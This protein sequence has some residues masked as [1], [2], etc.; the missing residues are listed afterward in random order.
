MVAVERDAL[1]LA[2]AVEPALVRELGP[3]DAVRAIL[4]DAGVAEPCDLAALPWRGTPLLTVRRRR[5]A[6]ERLFV[7][8]DAAS[9][10]EPFTGEG[11][12]WAIAGAL[13]AAPLVEAAVAGWEPSLASRWEV[14]YK[15]LLGQRQAFCRQLSLALR[16]PRA[17]SC[18]IALL[19]LAPALGRAAAKRTGAPLIPVLR[20]EVS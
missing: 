8:G 10:V 12:A 3:A 5:V 19:R 4:R 1:D 2:A 7:V 15:R 14:E 18:A 17:V 11:M 13:A 16:R 9:F 6:A 20:E